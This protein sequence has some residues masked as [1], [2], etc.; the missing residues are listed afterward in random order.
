MV[1]HSNLCCTIFQTRDWALQQKNYHHNPEQTM[2][3]W[4]KTHPHQYGHNPP[5]YGGNQQQG[6]EYY[7]QY[8]NQNYNTYQR[9]YDN[10]YGYGETAYP[11][12][13]IYQPPPIAYPNHYGPPHQPPVP[14]PRPPPPPPTPPESSNRD[15]YEERRG[16]NSR[17]AYC[18]DSRPYNQ[19]SESVDYCS[20]RRR[21]SFSAYRS[22]SKKP[23]QSS[24]DLE[25]TRYPSPPPL[26][27]KRG[28]QKEY[29]SEEEEDEYSDYD[30]NLSYESDNESVQSVIT[31]MRDYSIT[32]PSNNQELHPDSEETEIPIS[33]KEKQDY[34][35]RLQLVYKTLPDQLTPPA[36]QEKETV[37]LGRGKLV[38]KAKPES[39]PPSRFIE[40][41]FAAYHKRAHQSIQ[42]VEVKKTEQEQKEGKESEKVKILSQMK[43]KLGFDKNPF[44]PR[45]LYNTD[46]GGWPEKVQPDDQ[47]TLLTYDF[48]PPSDNFH[49]KRKEL[50]QIQQSAALSLNAST[51]VDWT[52][53]AVRKL[54]ADAIACG[55]S[56]TNHLRAIHDLVEGAAYANEFIADQ[57][58][59]VHG[60]I[61]HKIRND[62]V[63]QMED[64][65]PTESTEPISQPYDAS[66]VFNGQISKIVKD[67]KERENAR[68]LK[69]LAK[70][71]EK[72]KYPRRRRPRRRRN[73]DGLHQ[74][75]NQTYGR[76]GR[77]KAGPR[78]NYGDFD[79]NGRRQRNQTDRQNNSRWQNNQQRSQ[80]N[81]QFPK[82]RGSKRNRNN[83]QNRGN[84]NR[85][86]Y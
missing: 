25:K 63:Q 78:Q 81:Q 66:A 62:Y 47:I 35:R 75:I 51:H 3:S 9:P 65:T 57:S 14:P 72:P 12:R 26:G 13:P 17:K 11:Y 80:N 82:S 77:S 10:N 54:L 19:H 64:L 71:K 30:R 67:V 4:H 40:K 45:W 49:F 21:E 24:P 55:S 43:P 37:S 5:T 58:I 44:N 16:I 31:L 41:K 69:L 38:V 70:Q 39:L 83:Q 8:Y 29:F 73:S 86:R 32:T 15:Y 52:F 2:Q 34:F 59:Y 56:V 36:P 33:E 28:N 42:T 74:F 27:S 60:G 18:E 6:Q 84:R 48:N 61:T 22:T 50:Q 46:K 76:S 79:H 53:A 7:S 23:R 68:A 1:L 20:E 85:D